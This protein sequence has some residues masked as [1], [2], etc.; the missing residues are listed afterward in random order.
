[1]EVIKGAAGASMYGARAG[2]GVI[3][4]KTKSGRRL[5]GVQFSV[6]SEGGVSDIERDFGL[7]HEHALLTDET[8]TRFCQNVAGQP[9]CARTFNYLCEQKRINN[10]LGDFASSPPGFPVDPGSTLTG[11]VLK[12]R[13]QMY[14]YPG[15]SYNAVAQEVQPHPFMQHTVDM[16]ARVGGT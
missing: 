5:E 14:G 10:A 13:F 8:G 11:Q 2:N 16:S 6:R 3:S 9:T 1:V 12:Q 4:I 15:T 7:A